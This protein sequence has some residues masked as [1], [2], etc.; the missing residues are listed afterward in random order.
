MRIRRQTPEPGWSENRTERP[1]RIPADGYRRLSASQTRS[2]FGAK[3]RA[4]IRYRIYEKAGG[5]SALKEALAQYSKARA[6]W[7]DLA[8]HAKGVYMA[9]ITVGEL[10]QLRGHW[11]DHLPAMDRDIAGLWENWLRPHQANPNRKWQRP[12]SKH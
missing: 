3:S 1:A 4:G 2:F 9:D 5:Q 7:A 12:S 11:L 8:N 6:T 10:P